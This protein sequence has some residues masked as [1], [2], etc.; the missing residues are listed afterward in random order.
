MMVMVALVVV[1]F[2]VQLVVVSFGDVQLRCLFK[3]LDVLV[4]M[5]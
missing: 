2:V 1:Q 4:L 3:Q 5:G